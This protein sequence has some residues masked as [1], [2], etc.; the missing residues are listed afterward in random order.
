MKFYIVLAFNFHRGKITYYTSRAT[1]GAAGGR[2]KRYHLPQEIKAIL[3]NNF[4]R[5][6]VFDGELASSILDLSKMKQKMLSKH[7]IP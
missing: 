4:V 1:E 5:L 3:T 6:F 7:Y 2:I